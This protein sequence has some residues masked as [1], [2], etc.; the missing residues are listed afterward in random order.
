MDIGQG[1]KIT[2]KRKGEMN[3]DQ[4]RKGNREENRGE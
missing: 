3:R 1:K 4:T 2:E